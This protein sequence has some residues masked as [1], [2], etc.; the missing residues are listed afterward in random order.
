[1]RIGMIL[2]AG[3]TQLDLTG[4]FEVFARFPEAEVLLLSHDL[5]PVYA[6][7]GM[8]ILPTQTFAE[9]GTLD[10]LFVPGGPGVSFAMQSQTIQDFLRQQGAS[11]QYVTSVCT[12]SLVLASAGL[13][14]GYRATTHWMSVDLLRYFGVIVADERVV[15]D[16][17]RITGGGVTAGIDFA[18]YLADVLYGRSHA[19]GI[20]LSLE[21]NP[22]PPFAGGHPS[23]SDPA[24]VAEARAKAAE[25]QEQ[26]RVLIERL[27]TEAKN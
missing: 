11:A 6:D 10:I 24:V 9:C 1:M 23:L 7:K 21:Y 25:Q 2:F 14:N 22:Q 17:N 26:R 19:Q 4:P 15:Q 18:L 13:L 12:G 5:Q 20:Q 27:V 16:R 8:G 3:F